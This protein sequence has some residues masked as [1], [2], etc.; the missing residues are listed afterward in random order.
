MIPRLEFPDKAASADFMTNALKAEFDHQGL[1]ELERMCV[2]DMI[3]RDEIGTGTLL[4]TVIFAHL[5][6]NG[7]TRGQVET[8]IVNL[9]DDFLERIATEVTQS[10]I[11]AGMVS[12][13]DVLQSLANKV[14]EYWNAEP[15]PTAT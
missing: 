8:K 5:C 2:A 6:A 12:P 10:A 14:I 9:P 1:N 11:A 3:M 15:L 7:F 13:A 4:R